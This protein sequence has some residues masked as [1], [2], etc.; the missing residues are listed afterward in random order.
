MVEICLVHI[1]LLSM[2][3]PGISSASFVTSWWSP[4]CRTRLDGYLFL[5]IIIALRLVGWNFTFHLSAQTFVLSRSLFKLAATELLHLYIVLV[6]TGLS[7]LHTS[8]AHFH[9]L[10]QVVNKDREQ[11]RTTYRALWD[12][13]IDR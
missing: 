6:R 4:K 9:Q 3:T 12:R 2:L 1:S 13:C 11:E 8:T 10:E 5:D 7:R